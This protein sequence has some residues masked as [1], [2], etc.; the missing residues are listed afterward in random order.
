MVRS[1]TDTSRPES[2]TQSTSKDL[3]S[4]YS[5]KTISNDRVRE[6]QNI[7]CCSSS[8]SK[9]IVLQSILQTQP[10]RISWYRSHTTQISKGGLARMTRVQLAIKSYLIGVLPSDLIMAARMLIFYLKVNP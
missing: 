1:S 5:K 9:K 7:K 2:A 10:I 4:H 3:A 6:M 8:I